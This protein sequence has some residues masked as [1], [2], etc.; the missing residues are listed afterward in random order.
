MKISQH[1]RV[2]DHLLGVD[3]GVGN[4]IIRHRSRHDTADDETVDAEV[5]D[6][7]VDFAFEME[8]GAFDEDPVDL[9]CCHGRHGFESVFVRVVTTG[10]RGKARQ[11]DLI[12]PRKAHREATLAL[13]VCVGRM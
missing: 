11:Q 10:R 6:D 1:R 9:R 5:V 3:V 12:W 4:A 2:G 13:R 7:L 8:V